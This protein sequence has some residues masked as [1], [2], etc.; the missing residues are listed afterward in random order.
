MKVLS[1]IILSVFSI[2]N[3]LSQSNYWKDVKS[4]KASFK[5]NN[6]PE[7][8]LNIT[9]L[10][11]QL[12]E[13]DNLGTELI[14]PLENGEFFE[15]KVKEISYLSSGLRLKY[16]NIK[17][18]K[19]ESNNDQIY[20]SMGSDGFNATIINEEKTLI[21]EKDDQ[22]YYVVHKHGDHLNE[23]STLKCFVNNN[24]NSKSKI[25]SEIINKS[26]NKLSQL[27]SSS[28]EV[29]RNYRIAIACT[30]GYSEFHF[31]DQGLTDADS[32]TDKK[33][34]VISA[35]NTSL[36]RINSVYE[37]ELSIT[38]TLIDENDD[39][40]FVEE[41]TDPFTDTSDLEILIEESQDVVDGYIGDSNYDI[42]HTFTTG[43]GG[44][45]S[46]RV[47]CASGG[48]AR[49]ITASTYPKGDGFD[50]DYVAH[51]IGH[52]FGANHTFN[53]CD[54]DHSGI[55]SVEPASG[56]SIMAYAG[57]CAENVQFYS[58]AYFNV[59][60]LAEIYENITNDI[61][62]TCPEET[63]TGNTKPTITTPQNYSI[64]KSTPF[65]LKT[66]ANDVDDI[67]LL[68][69]CW[70][71]IDYEQADST[72][73]ESTNL[74]G[75]LFRSFEPTT[76][77]YR[78]FPSMT[79]ILSG[80]TSTDWEVLPSV[81][82]DLNFSL[83][84]R[85]NDSRGGLFETT[86]MVVTVEDEDAFY[87]TSLD[88]SE[89][90]YT[91]EN[92]TITWEVGGSTNASIN[93]QYVDIFISTDGG[94]TFDYQLNNSPIQNDGETSIIV[95]SLNS[96]SCRIMIKGYENIF[97]DVNNSNFTIDNSNN[98]YLMSTQEN[99]LSLCNTENATYEIDLE[100]INDFSETITLSVVDLP[101]GAIASFSNNTISESTSVT[102]NVTDLDSL[103]ADN[104]EFTVNASSTSI[105]QDL[106][107]NLII[108][109]D[110][111]DTPILSSPA[112]LE[113]NVSVNAEFVWN[114][115]ASI[116]SSN[117]QVA[118]D[119]NFTDL[120]IDTVVNENL[121]SQISL[122]P[123]TSVD[124][125][126]YYWRVKTTNNCDVESEYSS[127]YSFSTE[128]LEYCSS[129]FL[130]GPAE[131][132]SNVTFEDIDNST[133]I[134]ND[135]YGDYTGLIAYVEAGQTYTI[136][137]TVDTQGDYIDDCAVFIDWDKNYEFD[138]SERYYLGRVEN[139]PNGT[140]TYDIEVPEY[141]IN[142]QTRMRVKAEWQYVSVGPCDTDHDDA[143]GETEDYTLDITNTLSTNQ[144]Q[145]SSDNNFKLLNPVHNFISIYSNELN[146][147]LSLYDITGKHLLTNYNLKEN[148]KIN[149][150]NL[151]KGF[152]LVN[153]NV[154]DKNYSFKIIKI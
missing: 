119:E 128:E 154:L 35:L 147:D 58:D 101:T 121:Y 140:L 102:L 149:V 15:F 39:I 150:S 56:S 82:R 80:A 50:I 122:E 129:N 53:D 54:G 120:V 73:L 84:V 5:G 108:S 66:E 79:T 125:Q 17:S 30:Y 107:L 63:L 34:A 41:A 8:E 94:E 142:G 87:I 135:G 118:T 75:P 23:T 123:S 144:F 112:N 97:F 113:T 62:S 77:S 141:A 81:A 59:V 10:K 138:D 61:S 42:G 33:N 32:E 98:S 48:K 22:G 7:Y 27:K 88:S 60:N 132:I 74:S 43:G 91:G 78:Y 109:N 6:L 72:P 131:Y 96:T 139:T 25:T 151:S 103:S 124:I 18:Y 93:C 111:I 152:Y 134:E 99:E 11:N 20:F 21:I 126:T 46:L 145:I 67:D 26:K 55:T 3:I 65:V 136:S 71:Q 14:F 28:T 92:Q 104:Y 137:M 153:I 76:E 44:L 19:G 70:E 106:T 12:N 38:M 49:A 85:D 130:G 114:Y 83:T 68:T 90:W 2:S 105:D 116:I 100:Y 13:I 40:I 133:S 148:S 9:G 29:L 110:T 146:Y 36:T 117:I 69:Y 64:P 4:S 127:I 86:N 1:I 37:N 95:P 24:R 51:E 143:Y 47:P 57:L 89:T 115:D 16:P 52:Q 45:A 31:S